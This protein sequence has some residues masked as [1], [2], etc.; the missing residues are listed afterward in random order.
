[1]QW[2]SILLIVALCLIGVALAI[3]LGGYI[4]FDQVIRRKPFREKPPKPGLFEN[5]LM[6]DPDRTFRFYAENGAR[7][8]AL[9]HREVDVTTE[10]GL[11]L[12]G[13]FFAAE[14]PSA[15]TV[16]CNHG[17]TSQAFGECASL[18]LYLLKNGYNALAVSHR[19]HHPSEGK[20]I[21]FGILDS[22]DALRWIEA[23]EGLVPGG[24]VALYGVSMGAA[25]VMMTVGRKDLPACVRCAVEDCGYSSPQEEF[26][27]QMKHLFH[28]PHIPLLP[29]ADFFCRR[30]AGYRFDQLDSVA[31]VAESE[32][33]VM[34]IHG[35]AD[36][37]VPHQM[38]LRAYEACNAPKELYL[39]K[40]APHAASCV[41][42]PE[43]Y[44]SRVTAFLDRYMG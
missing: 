27:Y 31:C 29:V 36:A 34:F 15:R 10:D 14:T 30:L 24:T 17:Y 41:W 7:L 33:P 9:P 23:V 40:G 20:Y 26:R 13:Y 3:V 11:K 19:A 44:V 28:L 35:D 12:K 39:A 22:R 1:M 18:I 38:T 2:W 21:G 42:E 25:T 6:G 16:I 4:L 43:T 5:K 8:K 32:V 37:F